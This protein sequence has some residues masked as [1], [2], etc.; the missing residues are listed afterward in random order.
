MENLLTLCDRAVEAAL[1]GDRGLFVEAL[2]ADGA[3]HDPDTA[4]E[5]GEALL[6]AQG[7]YLPQFG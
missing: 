7:A 1:R 2:L 5:M 3:L 4:R 6:A